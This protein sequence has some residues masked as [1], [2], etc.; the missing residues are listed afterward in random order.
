M[1][2]YHEPRVPKG[3]PADGE[4]DAWLEDGRLIFGKYVASTGLWQIEKEFGNDSNFATADHT[5]GGTFDGDADTID[6]IHAA[7]LKLIGDW[8]SSGYTI[9]QGFS[10]TYNVLCHSIRFRK[11]NGYLQLEGYIARDWAPIAAQAVVLNIP[12]P[13]RPSH[14]VTM[15]NVGGHVFG[16]KSN[17]DV[18]VIDASASCSSLNFDMLYCNQVPI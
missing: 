2:T 10:E 17:G 18:F 14:T 5:H 15:D 7:S 11:N 4:R 12:S 13:F 9:Y 3:E 8:V 16:I 1:G 6:G